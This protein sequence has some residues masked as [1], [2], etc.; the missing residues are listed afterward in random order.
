MKRGPARAERQGRRAASATSVAQAGQTV[1]SG[2]ALIAG[3]IAGLIVAAVGLAYADGALAAYYSPRV[4][5]FYPLVVALLIV[6]IAAARPGLKDVELDVL[7]VALGAFVA[8][9]LAAAAASSSG[10]L[11]WFG[12]YNRPGGTVLWVAVAVLVFAARRL[13]PSRAALAPFVWLISA[14]IALASAVSLAQALSIRTPWGFADIWAG[15]MAGTTGNPLD[16]AGL[17]LLAVWLGVMAAT[18]PLRLPT[19]FAAALASAMGLL[20]IVLS[21]SRA[22]YIG[23]AAA[24]LFLIVVWVLSHRRRLVFMLLGLTVVVAAATIV[25]DP[26]DSGRGALAGRLSTDFSAA[27]YGL[28]QPDVARGT[29]WN[30]AED[31]IRARPWLGLGPGAYVV[32]YRRYVPAAVLR[33]APLSSVTDSHSLPLLIATGSGL[34]GLGLASVVVVLVGRRA[35]PE[36]RRA[37]TA[38]SPDGSVVN[39]VVVASAATSLALLAFLSLSPSDLTGLAAF[40][41]ML[42]MTA[43]PPD[44]SSRWTHR[45]RPL[46]PGRLAWTASLL[47]AIAALGATAAAGI[48]L[49]RADAAAHHAV[50]NGDLREAKRASDLMPGVPVYDLLAWDM[51]VQ[52]TASTEGGS[53]GVRRGRAYLERGLRADPTSP[54]VRVAL[55]RYHLTVREVDAALEQLRAGLDDNPSN[56]MLQ[57]LL[58]FVA[59]ALAKDPEREAQAVALTEEVRSLPAKSADGWYWLSVALEATGDRAGAT[60]ALAQARRLAPGLTA[61]DYAD[62]IRG[63]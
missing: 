21:V 56:P 52:S 31:A 27:T 54:A 58:G 50:T 24:V 3:V 32:A 45:F 23:L 47:V 28:S 11:A 29:F 8:V 40:A 48:Q 17:C 59:Q 18:Y 15:R 1:S 34:I 61:T 14:V 44:V 42:A 39:G 60:A 53:D 38:P 41:L 4:M 30:V 51:M 16:L 46:R 55:A 20:A 49:Y 13:L 26:S 5:L 33:D 63:L 62:R 12:S 9:Q 37:A 6:W 36:L 7:D 22:A 57:G 10:Q 25:Y 43:G 19:R 2:A 35:M